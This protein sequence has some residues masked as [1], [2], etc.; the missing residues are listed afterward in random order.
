MKQ[1]VA[2]FFMCVVLFGLFSCKRNEAETSSI[3]EPNPDPTPLAQA[4]TDATVKIY[5][6]NTLSMDGYINGNTGFKDAF[7][8]LLVAVENENDIDFKTEFYLINNQITKTDFGV[9][10]TKISEKLTPKNTADK[11]DKGSSEFEEE[12]DKILENQTGNT[13][14]VI[15][16]DFI[17]SPKGVK[18]VPSAL[19]KLQTYTENAFLKAG[20]GNNLDTRIYWFNSD[21]NGIYYDY[22]NRK[23]SGINNRPYYYIAIG[24]SALLDIFSSEIAPQIKVNS[25]FE[26]QALFT[27]KT[28]S[29]IDV[30]LIS[31]A[32]NG[33][34]KTRG[35]NIQVISYPKK[36]KLEFIA[37][38]DLGKLPVNEK[39]LLDKDNYQLK[40]PEFQME[41][42][43]KVKGKNL[44]FLNSGIVKMDAS[45]LVSIKGRHYTHAI[46]FSADGLASENLTFSLEKRIPSWVQKVNS[47]DDRN[48]QSD[49]LEQKRTFSF[50]HLVSGISEA[51]RQQNESNKYF[52]ITIPITN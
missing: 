28:Y 20:K 21:F 9:P 42:V 41:E 10:T 18:D 13:I 26:N 46:I 44:E 48:I 1:I 23:I 27:A 29:D 7:R 45:T 32:I 22:K 15:M 8:Q 40:N 3:S 51:Y 36:G 34:I 6:E 37:L 31:S 19:N 4:P 14:S 35:G 16:A 33:R 17:Y 52:T 12:L 25:G 47:N 11:G 50:G 2:A 49:S 43:G 30:K 39:Y 38:V 5:F 24:P